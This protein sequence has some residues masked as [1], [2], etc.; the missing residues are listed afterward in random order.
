MHY[1]IPGNAKHNNMT[2]GLF[3]FVSGILGNARHN[4]ITDGLFLIVSESH[5]PL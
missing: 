1:S 5:G 2:D 3:L 4:N